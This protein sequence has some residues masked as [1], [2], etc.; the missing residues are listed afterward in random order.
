MTGRRADD[1]RDPGCPPVATIVVRLFGG[2][3]G[4]PG[5]LGLGLHPDLRISADAENRHVPV[6]WLLEP[7]AGTFAL[8]R[9]FDVSLDDRLILAIDRS[10]WRAQRDTLAAGGADIRH[11][12]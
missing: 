4:N 8:N 11:G 3:L 5:S 9:G 6:G 10:R 2:G 1:R 12:R 7:R